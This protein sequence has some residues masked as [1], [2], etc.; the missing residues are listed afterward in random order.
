MQYN[1]LGNTDIKISL[2]CLGT[3]TYGSDHTEAEAH[4]QMDY[5]LEQGVNFFD[6]A[7]MYPVPTSPEYQ[8]RN[9]EIIGSWLKKRGSRDQVVVATKVAAPADMTRYLRPDMAFDR[10][11]IR[12]AVTNSLK[13]LQTDYIDL[14]QLHWPE[15]KTNFFGQL[16][17]EHQ[18]DQDGTPLLE[19]LEALG[20]LV[21]EGLVRHIGL[22]NE[23]AWGTM[24]F[25]QLAEQHGLPRAV[26]VQNP[27]NFLN[28]TVEVGLTEVLHR[29][30]VSLLPYSPLAFGALSGKYIGGARPEGARITKYPAYGR[31]FNEQGQKAVEA[32]VALAQ[33]HELDP[34]MMALA[35]VN[36]RP[37]VDANIIGASSMAQLKANI[38]SAN[39]T[40]SDELL[41]EIEAINVL[42]PNPC[43]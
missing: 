4:E 28:R 24:K 42:Y 7:E 15:R 6:G 22:S 11:N 26:S 12:E 3:M 29:E 18:P 31:Y 19:T 43:P 37:F 36:N 16:N 23:S 21:D 1:T 25:L 8:G 38:E 14:Y 30:G 34:C 9:E 33:K 32:Y 27:F 35:W 13:R 5:A 39:V 17:Y 41:A 40:L 2:I 10:R 20:E